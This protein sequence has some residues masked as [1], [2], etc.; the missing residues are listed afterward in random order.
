MSSQST[1]PIDERMFRVKSSTAKQG[2]RDVPDL[3][4]V[5]DCSA[6]SCEIHGPCDQ[7]YGPQNVPLEVGGE[8]FREHP[9]VDSKHVAF[10]DIEIRKYP[11][12]LGDHP[13]CCLG[14]PVSLNRQ[15]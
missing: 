13:E 11:V 14:P 15:T 8:K 1:M 3:E 6:S 12:I 2:N 10:G 7:D 4:P 9:F 5:S